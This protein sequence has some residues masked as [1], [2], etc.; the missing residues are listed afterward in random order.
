MEFPLFR[1]L[2]GLRGRAR[3]AAAAPPSPAEPVPVEIEHAGAVLT[4][5]LRRSARARR[6]SM[7]VDP[8]GGAIRLVVPDR[9]A[10][11]R[12]IDFARANAGWIAAR[13]R[14]LPDRVPFA[15]GVALPL[16]GTPHV[17]RHRADARG[18]VWIEDGE[19]HVAGRP[20]HLPRRLWDWFGARLSERMRPLVDDKAALIERR[21]GRLTI[22]DTATQ[23][24]S[25]ARD[26]DMSFSTRLV[27]APPEI[28][29]YLAAHEV[30]HL[31]YRNHGPRFWATAERLT[32]G[33]MAACKAWLRR[34]GETLMRYG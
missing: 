34:H 15:D 11:E 8:R 7:R 13:T 25:C 29:D 14:R 17:V 20:E 10:K 22:R 5:W 21:A 28:L 1:A 16:F 2:A 4:I 26:G 12:A 3:P 9:M 31:A 19:L 33:D 24:G 30:A 23:W 18:T 6:V 32:D 27:F